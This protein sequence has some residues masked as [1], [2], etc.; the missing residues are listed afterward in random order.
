LNVI[1]Y[2]LEKIEKKLHKINFLMPLMFVCYTINKKKVSIKK[3]IKR[4]EKNISRYNM[5]NYIVILPV[6]FISIISF[7]L[8]AYEV[9][10]KKKTFFI[11]H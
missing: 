1:G 11:Q 3:D 10:L 7:V 4:D 8:M 5:L 6:F 9:I 2:S